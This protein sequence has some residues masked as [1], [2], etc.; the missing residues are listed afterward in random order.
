[1]RNRLYWENISFC[2]LLSVI[3]ALVLTR[4]DVTPSNGFYIW[5]LFVIII[6]LCYSD[7]EL[8]FRKATKA[9][10]VISFVMFLTLTLKGALEI[11]ILG[12][13]MN[14]VSIGKVSEDDFL[15]N[16]NMMRFGFFYLSIFLMTIPMILMALFSRN[17][18]IYYG[19]KVF[20]LSYNETTPIEKW[21]NYIIKIGSLILAIL[22]IMEQ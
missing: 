21:I 4:G 6:G 11:A 17:R 12:S 18:L 8:N 15:K 20:K 13:Y 22:I 5:I 14:V 10:L 7:G 3:C 2:S 16:Q 19:K 1:M 9:S